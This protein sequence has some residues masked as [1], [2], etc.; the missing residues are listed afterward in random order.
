MRNPDANAH[1]VAKSYCYCD[2]NRYAYAD[3]Y[4]YRN[5]NSYS[6]AHGDA[7]TDADVRSW[8]YAWSVDTGSAGSDRSLRRLHGQRWD[9]CL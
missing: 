6:H 8:R 5:S 2:S 1:R 3:S 4:A 9:L 7:L